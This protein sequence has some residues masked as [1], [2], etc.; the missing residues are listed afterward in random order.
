[1]G[2]VGVGVQRAADSALLESQFSVPARRPWIATLLLVVAVVG[3]YF[4]VHSYPFINFDDRD[5]VYENPTVQAGL[6]PSTVVWAFTT[7]NAGNWHPLT[8]LSHA[9]DCTLFGMNPAGHHIVNVLFHAIDA[10]LLFWV[11][12]KATGFMGRSFMVAALFAL[13]PIN[14]ESVAWIAERKTV[15]STMFF[16]LALAAYRWYASRPRV[17]RYATVAA[18]FAFGLMAK[19]QIITLPFVLLLWDYWPLE[20]LAV[21]F[22]RFA[23]RQKYGADHSG[24][25]RTAKSEQ[26]SPGEDWDAKCKERSLW[27]LLLE[28]VPLLAIAAASA[29]ITMRA[30]Y[31]A[32]NHFER[33][34]R[35]G[36]A[37]LSYGLYIKRAIWPTRLALLYPHPGSS[38]SWSKV[39]ASGA[40]LLSITLLTVVLRRHRYLPVGWFWFLGTLVPMLGIVQV[41]IQAMADRYAYISFIG[42]FIMICWGAAEL[43]KRYGAPRI[44]LPGASVAWLLLLAILA[45]RQITYWQND[46]ALWEHTLQVTANNWLAESQLGSALAMTGKIPEGVRHFENALAINSDD[47]NSNM[48]MGIYNSMQGNFRAAVPYYEKALRDKSARSSFQLRG[49]L[50]LAKA[51]RA[52]GETARS[53][54][55][56]QEASKLSP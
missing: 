56:L 36:N 29:V 11:L 40:V 54:A 12:L 28:K 21:R 14:V 37:I 55:C 32:R 34:D 38:I 20:R 25:E 35:A 1:M 19:P 27:W 9:L 50:G 26:R 6:K 18:L 31:L 3:L 10:V 47:S 30:Q 44:L 33:I 24:E 49:Y 42:L 45:H 7:Y 15:L 5:Y 43:A 39:I 41:G 8:W 2:A 4:P 23:F 48:G 17:G 13:H 46:E 16:L 52:L 22:S 51:Y 53:Q